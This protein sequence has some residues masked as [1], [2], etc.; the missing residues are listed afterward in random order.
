MGRSAVGRNEAFLRNIYARGPFQGH[1]FICT[2][3]AV[4][5]HAHPGYDYTIL[6][7]P[8]EDW[9]P[10]VVENYEAQVRMNGLL[11]DDAV[12]CARLTTGTH[13]Y[14]AAFGCEVHR[15]ADNMPCA[16]PIEFFHF[17][18]APLQFV[19]R[20]RNRR[21]KASS[22]SRGDSGWIRAGNGLIVKSHWRGSIAMRSLHS[23]ARRR[24]SAW[25]TSGGMGHVKPKVLMISRSTRSSSSRNWGRKSFRGR[26]RSDT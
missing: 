25:S 3:P 4:P 6:R 18:Y 19:V 24:R 17:L 22:A 10:W 13:L 14:A 1:A 15:F 11:G 26:G 23:V 2:P 9:A 16:V 12:P 8:V 21:R 5:I 20:D 7:E